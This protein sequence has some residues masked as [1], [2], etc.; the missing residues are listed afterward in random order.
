MRI[1][2]LVRLNM[3][4]FKKIRMLSRARGVTSVGDENIP[5]SDFVDRQ[6]DNVSGAQ[7]QEVILI[8]STQRSG[9]TYLC[10]L[11]RK[12]GICIAHEYFQPYQYMPILAKRWGAYHSDGSIDRDLYFSSLL[13]Y[14]CSSS[15]VLGINLHGGHVPNFIPYLKH[16]QGVQI[17]VLTLQRKDKI[18]QAVSYHIAS[19]ESRWSSAYSTA[20][21][22]TY[23]YAGIE[24]KLHAISKGE[25]LNA[26]LLIKLQ[27]GGSLL[28]YEDMVADP[29]LVF[30][31]LGREVCSDVADG[32][33]L[34]K[35][36]D[37]RNEQ[38]SLRFSNEI[39][40]KSGLPIL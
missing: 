18:A 37:A 26:A 8:L 39:V 16:L 6:Y 32:V 20:G 17:S 27:R 19:A 4:F 33:G 2:Q 22:A 23:S 28:Y 36:A 13:K 15:G 9:S 5:E 11:L 7:L 40:R 10:D 34:K 12:S 24:K 31:A 35:Q 21:S 38:W 14:R 30:A 25:I 3:G 1:C 29:C